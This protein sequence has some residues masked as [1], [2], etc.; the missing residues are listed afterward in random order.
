MSA[1]G[2]V[3]LGPG[4]GRFIAAAGTRIRVKLSDR[5]DADAPEVIELRTPPGHSSPIH[6]HARTDHAV[7]VLEGEITLDLDGR[8]LEAPAG[9]FFYVPRGVRHGLT[10]SGPGTAAILQFDAGASLEAMFEG[11]A[12]AFPTAD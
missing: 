2:V 11:L 7:F 12:N 3:V 4:Q 5:D 9:A 10:N 1:D 8:S 6:V